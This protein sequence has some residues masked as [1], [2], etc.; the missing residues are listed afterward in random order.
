MLRSASDLGGDAGLAQLGLELRG[1]GGE[2]GFPGAAPVLEPGGHLAVVVRLEIAEGQVLQLPF[3]LP[4][5]Q[6][7]GQRRVDL[8]GTEGEAA[9]K[10]RRG[11]LGVPQLMQALGEQYQDHAAVPHHRQEQLTQ[12]LGMGRGEGAAFAGIGLEAR[13]GE[14]LPC[15]PRGFDPGLRFQAFGGDTAR[16]HQRRRH[17][18]LHDPGIELE[19]LEYPAYARGTRAHLV[20]KLG[21]GGDSVD[22]MS[23][24]GG[25]GG[26]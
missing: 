12:V 18:R 17:A 6:A 8:A 5:T 13:Q 7:V 2:M 24:C 15:Q 21:R 1:G 23:E 22:D 26:A 14:H 9:L 20:R 16:A 19:T 4:D 25:G 11:T 3:E 10:F